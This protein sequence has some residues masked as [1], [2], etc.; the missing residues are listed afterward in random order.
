MGGGDKMA[1][2]AER[3]VLV[4]GGAGFLG[5]HVVRNIREQ[6]CQTVIVPRSREFD[7]REKAAIIRLLEQARPD[8]VLHLAAP[9]GGIGANRHHPEQFSTTTPSWGCS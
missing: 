9:V 1:F 4:T 6:G 5:T 3:R 8:V 7:L 2:W